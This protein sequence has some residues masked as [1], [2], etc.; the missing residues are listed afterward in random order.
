VFD[1]RASGSDFTGTY[2]SETFCP[3]RVAVYPSSS[4]HSDFET[5]SALMTTIGIA[6]IFVF[7]IMVFALYDFLVERRQ[8]FLAEQAHKSTAIVSSLFPKIVR[9]RLFDDN[10]RNGNAK[11]G[12]QNFLSHPPKLDQ[13][14]G[15]SND[16]PIADLFKN[17]T[18]MFGDIAGFT[19]WSST[20]QPT[21]VFIL[22]ETLYSAFDRIATQMGV[23][24]VETIGDCYVA[25]TGLPNVQADHH[26]RMVRFARRCLDE[27]IVVT[28]ELEVTLGPDTSNLGFRVGLH[29]GAVTAGV[30]RGQKARFQIFGDTVNMA[31]RMES[32]GIRNRIQISQSTA[33]LLEQ[34]GRDHWFHKRDDIVQAKGKGQV[35]TYWIRTKSSS[36]GKMEDTLESKETHMSNTN[37]RASSHHRGNNSVPKRRNNQ[38]LIDWQ[39]ALL[40]R[41]IKQIVAHRGRQTTQ[42]LSNLVTKEV[43]P[44]EL[45]A[46]KISMPEFSHE[47]S[48]R[49]LEATSVELPE[50]VLQQLK[51]LVTAIALLYNDNS[52][53]NFNHACHVTMTAN[54]LLSR[55]VVPIEQNTDEIMKEAHDFSYGLTSDPLTQFAIVFSA[56]IHDLEH[57]G[58][59]NG[60]LVEEENRLATLYHGESVAEQ[61]SID[62]TLELLAGSDYKDLVSCIC[63]NEEEFARFRQLVINC[64]LATDV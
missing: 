62:L 17:A 23:F 34:D 11:R 45:I 14:D 5:K 18:V 9:D 56:L 63:A 59:T 38:T 46:E 22:L 35:Q 31:A 1:L 55:V 36:A 26:M 48:K 16:R 43:L 7:T 24:K 4:M 53:H 50:V 25:V 40:S 64:V 12:L 44:R 51:D 29:S 13:E 60:Q 28:K 8:K 37:P 52:F 21:E 19:A 57:P 10:D 47:K 42:L 61:H 6:S 33:E 49:C 41:L 3:Y 32:T 30:L 39:V 58:V 27:M 54:K 15:M 20:R 2:L